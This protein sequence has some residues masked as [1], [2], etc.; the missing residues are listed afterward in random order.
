LR[1]EKCRRPEAVPQG[2]AP[3]HAELNRRLQHCIPRRPRRPLTTRAADYACRSMAMTACIT[4]R[5][6]THWRLGSAGKRLRYW[7]LLAAKRYAPGAL[8]LAL[9]ARTFVH[10]SGRLEPNLRAG[11]LVM[12]SRSGAATPAPVCALFPFNRHLPTVPFFIDALANWL[13]KRGHSLA[14]YAAP[15]RGNG[16]SVS[17]VLSG[18]MPGSGQTAESGG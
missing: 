15:S 13:N 8:R 2:L 7:P 14:D 5:S 9:Q 1:G 16:C 3:G 4:R 18:S 12:F 10:N 11:R 17:R 6:E